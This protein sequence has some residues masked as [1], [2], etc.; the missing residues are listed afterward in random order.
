MHG[1]DGENPIP[2]E[3]STESY[4]D[5]IERAFPIETV[6]TSEA[7]AFGEALVQAADEYVGL[8][9]RNGLVGEE[10]A[11]EIRNLW[12]NVVFLDVDACAYLAEDTRRVYGAVID[13]LSEIDAPELVADAQEM[14][15]AARALIINS[16]V[17]FSKGLGAV[18]RPNKY[19]YYE[20]FQNGLPETAILVQWS[21]VQQNIEGGD[22]TPEE[23]VK[24]LVEEETTH[25]VS[26][27]DR[28]GTDASATWVQ[29]MM[30]RVVKISIR[31]EDLDNA[32]GEV[33]SSPDN[34]AADYW[35]LFMRV[36]PDA[37]SQTVLVNMFFG[38]EPEDS[39]GARRV[40][41]ALSDP[42]FAFAGRVLGMGIDL[43]SFAERMS[44]AFDQAGSEKK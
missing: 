5:R 3:E 39:E 22:N 30:A 13:D 31:M 44:A 24:L 26:E 21:T 37:E 7:R 32:W 29:E 34:L 23:L 10:K 25:L 33:Q 38:N 43:K 27:L 35:K 18:W 6:R 11:A 41:E 36:C 42:S 4:S 19:L 20:L 14:I 40:T 28:Y 9:E 1:E 15:D 2:Y 17:M 16:E 12:E 8:F